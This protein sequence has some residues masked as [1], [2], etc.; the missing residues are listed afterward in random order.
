MIR[1]AIAAQL[2][3]I[4]DLIDTPS[5]GAWQALPGNRLEL[6]ATGYWIE[7]KPSDPTADLI[8]YTP[9]GFGAWRGREGQLAALKLKAEEC[10]RE[11][12]EFDAVKLDAPAR[13]WRA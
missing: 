4:A 8:L 13:G 3:R 11:R 9:E 5:R 1:A 12:G 7:L 6:G 2:R 10:A